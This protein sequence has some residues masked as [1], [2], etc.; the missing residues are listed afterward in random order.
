MQ[1]IYD[2]D[3]DPQV[4]GHL[5]WSSR[6]KTID[7]YWGSLREIR[8]PKASRSWPYVGG[9]YEVEADMVYDKGTTKG[10]FVYHFHGDSPPRIVA[11]QL[12][13]YHEN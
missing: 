11:A 6:K 4:K 7:L 1:T 5:D 13:D 12:A 9:L 10:N 8:N 2:N 3:T